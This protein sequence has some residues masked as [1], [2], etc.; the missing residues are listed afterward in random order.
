MTKASLLTAAIAITATLTSSASFQRFRHVPS[1][2]R[3]RQHTELQKPYIPEEQP[4]TAT[5]TGAEMLDT[6]TPLRPA[7]DFAYA[8]VLAPWVLNGYRH[9]EPVKF[10]AKD[11]VYE[12]ST[13]V[14]IP[15]DSVPSDSMPSPEWIAIEEDGPSAKTPDF[16]RPEWL[17]RENRSRQFTLDMIHSLMTLSPLTREYTK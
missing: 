11:A 17:A 7:S 15:A 9:L 12:E 16:S 10:K 13:I 14:N 6:I 1:P 8:A 3:H 4:D 2:Q 5:L